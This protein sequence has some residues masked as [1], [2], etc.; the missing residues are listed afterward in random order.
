MIFLAKTLDQAA[1]GNAGRLAGRGRRPDLDRARRL[2]DA[3]SPTITVV[4][5][6]QSAR[7]EQLAGA[8]FGPTQLV[9]I[10]LEGPRRS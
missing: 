2:E 9:P 5:G 10:L 1:L 4:P 6:T 8:Q 3:L 7:A